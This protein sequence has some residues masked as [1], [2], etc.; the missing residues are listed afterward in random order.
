MSLCAG[1]FF[2]SKQSAQDTGHEGEQWLQVSD[3]RS[4]LIP[5]VTRSTKARIVIARL[6]CRDG[7]SHTM[8]ASADGEVECGTG[9]RCEWD[10]DRLRVEPHDSEHE[11]GVNAD[12]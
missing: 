6:N 10:A 11:V 12:E 7:A 1:P 8:A 5:C 3:Y 9:D 4:Q 2:Q